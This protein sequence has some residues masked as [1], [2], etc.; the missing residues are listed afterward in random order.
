MSQPP[1][2]GSAPLTQESLAEL[3]HN[4]RTPVNHIVGYAE[5]LA[6]DATGPG[7]AGRRAHLEE[8]IA[9]ARDILALIASMLGSNH[10]D[11][12]RGDVARLYEALRPPRQ[13]IVLAVTA[14]LGAPDAQQDASLAEDLGRVLAAAGR[15]AGPAE[16][17]AVSGVPDGDAPAGPDAAGAEADDIGELGSIWF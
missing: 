15:L 1:P 7:L 4:L 6:E 3:R 11:V 2:V 9:A 12:S 10:A 13:R 17:T 14:V 5:M 8:T 16:A